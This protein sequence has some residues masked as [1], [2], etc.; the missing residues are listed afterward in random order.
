MQTETAFITTE[1]ELTALSEGLQTIIPIMNLME[2][3]QEQG[4]IMINN[5]AEIE[6]KVFEDNSGALAIDA[7]PKDQI[8][9][10]QVLIFQG[11]FIK[12][13]SEADQFTKLLEEIYFDKLTVRIMGKE[14]QRLHKLDGEWGKNEEIMNAGQHTAANSIFIPVLKATSVLV[15]EKWESTKARFKTNANSDSQNANC[16]NA[17]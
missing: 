14:R 15:S 1:A 17:N 4:V 3:M 10:Y 9:K 12:Q 6:C 11:A 8:H 7:L 2:E 5:K 13:G 16:P